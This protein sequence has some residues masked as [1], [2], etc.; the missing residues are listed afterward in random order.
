MRFSCSELLHWCAW[1]AAW[2]DKE[3]TKKEASVAKIKKHLDECKH[4]RD[5]MQKALKES[6]ETMQES[7]KYCSSMTQKTNSNVARLTRTM[8]PKGHA[9]YL[10][11]GTVM[12]SE[13]A[14]TTAKG[15]TR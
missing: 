5:A 12:K 2:L 11:S 13:Q 15:T 4:E 7:V 6:T 1:Q 14:V 9:N 3:I 8:A 10:T